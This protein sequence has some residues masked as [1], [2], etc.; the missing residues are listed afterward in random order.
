[1]KS[2]ESK[3]GGHEVPGLAAAALANGATEVS[4]AT[5]LAIRL[6]GLKVSGSRGCLTW[7]TDSVCVY[8]I[9]D[10]VSASGGRADEQASLVMAAH[11]E[12]TAA[13]LVAA[14]RIQTSML[15]FAAGRK[16]DAV[17]ASLLIYPPSGS[18]GG[19]HVEIVRGVLAQAKPGQILL[20]ETVAKPWSDFPGFQF[21][22]AS[23][24]GGSPNG[25]LGLV[26]LMWTS[27]E[28][29]ARLQDS[30]VDSAA[31]FDG[32]LS[33]GATMMVSPP[34]AVTERAGRRSTGEGVFGENA[35]TTA[36]W[37]NVS[38]ETSSRAL[39]E[40]D[41][42]AANAL[43]EGLEDRP[44]RSFFSPMRVILGAA[45]IILVA[46]AVEVLY[47]PTPMKKIPVVL[48]DSYG[49]AAST[50]ASNAVGGTPAT[51][52]PAASAGQ[53]GSTA[54][55]PESAVKPQNPVINPPK[56]K[57]FKA[58]VNGSKVPSDREAKSQP[59][60]PAP[61][62]EIDGWSKKDI[63]QLL[64]TAQ[65][66]IG[67]GRYEDARNA[68]SKILQLQPD[69][70]DAKDGLRKIELIKRDSHP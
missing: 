67:D 26:E 45:A 2:Y 56:Q 47:K 13:A 31:P 5:D 29:L 32:G 41:H 12:T 44:K 46:V 4:S 14:K 59:A 53:P 36:E 35:S 48:P 50:S 63:P 1:M 3:T 25:Q 16:G 7:G 30:V 70:Q 37:Q 17:A 40:S 27:A 22:A 60:P 19:M 52:Q 10:L 69:N 15:E 43:L 66:A 38:H 39:P 21:R 58:P 57:P 49:G 68:Y 18:P 6:W 23:I 54:T 42:N 24:A 33:M 61:V 51:S 8:M 28:D 65:S 62:D 11:F 34:S 9:A 64:R 20:G 55:A